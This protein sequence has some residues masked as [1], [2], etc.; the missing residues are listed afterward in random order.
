MHMLDMKLDPLDFADLA[1]AAE[2]SLEMLSDSF[3]AELEKIKELLDEATDKD[4]EEDE[5]TDYKE[6]YGRV[7][8]EAKKYQEKFSKYAEKLKENLEKVYNDAIAKE[9]DVKQERRE[10]TAEKSIKSPWERG[11]KLGC[12]CP[13]CATY[14]EFHGIAPD[15]N[16]TIFLI[17]TDFED[18]GPAL[19]SKKGK[20]DKYAEETGSK[21][22]GGKLYNFFHGDRAEMKNILGSYTKN[23]NFARA[24]F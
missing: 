11:H 7:D 3:R 16:K 20:T 13:G 17:A 14:R 5:E 9:T 24:G 1:E 8:E 2:M 22:C 18:A 12:G 21:P 19:K 23:F 15:S 4:S 10:K 6:A